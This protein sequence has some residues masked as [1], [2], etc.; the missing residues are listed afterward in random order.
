MLHGGLWCIGGIALTVADIGFVFWGAILFGGI[1]FIKG[2]T[3][4]K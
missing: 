2:L 1:Q 3:N 4:L